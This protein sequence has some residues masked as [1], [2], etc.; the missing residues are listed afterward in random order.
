M[1]WRDQSGAFQAEANLE[2]A[3]KWH[4]LMRSSVAA[5][6]DGIRHFDAAL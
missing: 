2:I 5:S 6:M 3:P 1:P 4:P